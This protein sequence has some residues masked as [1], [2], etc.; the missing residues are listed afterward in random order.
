VG[1][2]GGGGIGVGYS[3][4]PRGVCG[5]CGSLSVCL[6]VSWPAGRS[7]CGLGC[8]CTRGWLK[9]ELHSFSICGGV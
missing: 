2:G 4:N 7:A 5:E 1:G 9:P 6:C 3:S 8:A